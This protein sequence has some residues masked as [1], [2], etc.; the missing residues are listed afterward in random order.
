MLFIK[1]KAKEAEMEKKEGCRSRTAKTGDCKMSE[2][3]S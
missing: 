1:K 3:W 2:M